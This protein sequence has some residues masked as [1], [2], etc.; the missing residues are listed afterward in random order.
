[1]FLKRTDHKTKSNQATQ[2]VKRPRV[3]REE[4]VQSSIQ[5]APRMPLIEKIIPGEGPM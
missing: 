2:G 1:M 4:A 3:S 5:E